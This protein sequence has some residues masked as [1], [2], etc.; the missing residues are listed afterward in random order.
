MPDGGFTG[1]ISAE[2]QFSVQRFESLD[3]TNDYAK[4]HI[5]SLG[6]GRII[7]ARTQTSGHGRMQ[8][9]W[10][11]P[12]EG[13][14]YFSLVLKENLPPLERI[15][16]ITQVA[17]IAVAQTLES[18]GLITSIK[19]PNDV[20]VS[21]K[22][23][24]GLLSETV[25]RRKSMEGVIVGIG[26]NVNMSGETLKTID[27]PAASMAVELK[28]TLNPEAVLS[29]FLE[30]FSSGFQL[31]LEQGFTGLKSQWNKYTSAWIGMKVTVEN[32]SI[33]GPGQILAL[34]DDGTIK[35]QFGAQVMDLCDGD[36]VFLPTHITTGKQY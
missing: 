28:K 9:K 3:S 30:N 24:C 2:M 35:I 32:G 6:H 36:I 34:N 22:K 8:R 12:P 19:W 11:S 20:L 27:Q 31:F 29:C 23:I 1:N 33:N 17:S 14:L 15:C 26:I 7:L 18:Y 10:I 4:E 13:N 5:S 25:V 21:G 16:N